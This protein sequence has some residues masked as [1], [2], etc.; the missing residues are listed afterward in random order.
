MEWS[1]VGTEGGGVQ[2]LQDHVGDIARMLLNVKG[3]F[4]SAEVS[5]SVDVVLDA[6]SGSK[7]TSTPQGAVLSKLNE[8]SD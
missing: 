6:I 2:L 1:A 4:L 7:R 5:G 8:F 3:S